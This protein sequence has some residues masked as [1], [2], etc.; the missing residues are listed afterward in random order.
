MKVTTYLQ[1]VPTLDRWGGLR[2]LKVA[3]ATT[4]APREPQAGAMT[5]QVE[6]D[7]PDAVFKPVLAKIVVPVEHVAP[8]VTS[9]GTLRVPKGA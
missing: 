5:L 7:V 8:V 9:V 3:R 2:G 1:I 4:K 6:I